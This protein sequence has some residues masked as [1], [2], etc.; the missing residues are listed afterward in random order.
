MTARKV[1]FDT[2]P[3]IDDACALALVAASPALELVGITSV[4][5]NAPV[6]TTTRNALYLR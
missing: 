1:I 6:G 5:G 2:D 3:G 4:F